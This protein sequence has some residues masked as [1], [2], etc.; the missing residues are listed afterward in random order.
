ML[1]ICQSVR[2]LTARKTD[3]E[4]LSENI[5]DIEPFITVPTAPIT[6]EV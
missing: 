1:I 3:I 4:I 5:V 6:A 2:R